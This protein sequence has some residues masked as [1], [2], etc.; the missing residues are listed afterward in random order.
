M[1]SPHSELVTTQQAPK[2]W[3]QLPSIGAVMPDYNL[4]QILPSIVP[5]L[6]LHSDPER[7]RPVS[8]ELAVH[9]SL[10][11]VTMENKLRRQIISSNSGEGSNTLLQNSVLSG[12]IA[13]DGR[14]NNWEDN[15]PKHDARQKRQW[16]TVLDHSSHQTTLSLLSKPLAGTQ[17]YII[18]LDLASN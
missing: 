16:L 1:V 7:Q 12:D 14:R 3:A 9:P 8:P 11:K 13:L 2:P 15:K 17:L 6:E 18:Y 5:P 10:G 4:G